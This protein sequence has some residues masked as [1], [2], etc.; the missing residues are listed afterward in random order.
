MSRKPVPWIAAILGLIAA[1]LAMLYVR[2]PFAALLFAVASLVIGIADFIGAA[3]GLLVG[4]LGWGLL[5]S[6]GVVAYRCAK[7]SPDS[8]PPWYARWYG[9]L[10]VAVAFSAVVLIFRIFLFEPFRI[11]SSAMLPTLPREA[12]IIVQKHGY[13][14]LSTFGI[15]LGRFPKSAGLKRGEIIVFDFPRDPS[16]TFIMRIVGL[17]DDRIT[18]VEKSVVVNGL[19]TRQQQLADYLD[20]EMLVYHHRYLNQLDATTFETLNDARATVAEAGAWDFPLKES[21][22]HSGEKV[23]CVVPAGRYFVMGDNRDN[24]LDSRYWGYVSSDQ[25]TGKLIKVFPRTAAN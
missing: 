6:G 19:Q 1:P 13:G 21:C 16:Q 8:A 20:A 14:H 11:P 10:A 5:L 15:D 17:P 25:I 22:S 2:R 18:F 3:D 4:L 24:S 9:L 12:N 7:V 23:E